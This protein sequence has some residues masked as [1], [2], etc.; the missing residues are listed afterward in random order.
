M[1]PSDMAEFGA[2][3]RELGDV[4]LEPFF[5]RQAGYFGGQSDLKPLLHTWSLS[6]EEQFYLVWP[7]VFLA[8][9]RWRLDG[10]PIS[11]GLRGRSRSPPRQ[12]W[13]AS[14][15]RRP[16]SSRPFA[17]GS[18]CSAPRWRSSTWRPT[19]PAWAAEIAAGVGLS[20]IVASVV[21]LDE[22]RPFPGLLALPA[23]LGTA[24]LILTGMD[25]Q[26]L[27]TRMLSL[28]PGCRHRAHLLLALPVALAAAGLRPLLLRPPA[29]MGR[30]R[31]PPGREPA[32]RRS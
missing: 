11:C 30:D 9:A 20:L 23:C 24:L 8:V 7:V 4:R 5:F 15:R 29:A 18:F 19:L 25:S 26:P 16:S 21:L 10:C 14:T 6:I 12:S 31:L 1:L 17:P 22:S 27:V 32:G 2:Q 28:R 3:P 13:S